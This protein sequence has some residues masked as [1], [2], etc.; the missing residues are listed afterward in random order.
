M[1]SGG[2][3]CLCAAFVFAL[4]T[5]K[6]DPPEAFLSRT[7][8]SLTTNSDPQRSPTPATGKPSRLT[9]RLCRRTSI[10]RWFIQSWRTPKTRSGEIKKGLAAGHVRQLL[11]GSAQRGAAVTTH[12]KA[13]NGDPL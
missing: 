6:T 4:G 8:K 5:L 9:T 1:F 7:H 10:G 13:E 2:I 3:L 12:L 11:N